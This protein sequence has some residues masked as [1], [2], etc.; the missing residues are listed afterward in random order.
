MD[1]SDNADR[2]H[3]L[4]RVVLLGAASVCVYAIIAAS[5]YFVW[6]SDAASH[7]TTE[8]PMA[9]CSIACLAVV[10]SFGAVE[11]ARFRDV[12][13]VGTFGLVV[14]WFLFPVSSMTPSDRVE[15]IFFGMWWEFHPFAICIGSVTG[16]IVGQ[17]LAE[18]RSG[19]NCL[20]DH[21][22]GR[23]SHERNEK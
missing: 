12:L 6:R 16:V 11:P 18:L 17:N 10:L 7:P 23:G 21:M 20:N 4:R 3:V 14:G 8:Q 15:A 22:G 19:L 2:G 1:R 9:L 5:F 13:V